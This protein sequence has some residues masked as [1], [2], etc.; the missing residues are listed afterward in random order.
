MWD[1]KIAKITI[2]TPFPVGDV[3]AYVVKG[4]VLT[5]IDGGPKTEEAKMAIETGLKEL[6]LQLNDIEQVIITHHHPDHIGGVD[7]FSLDLPFLGH[8]NNQRFLELS[9]DFI[10]FNHEFFSGFLNELGVPHEIRSRV[11]NIGRLMKYGCERTLTGF[12]QD[13]DE[14]PGL[15]GW[16][17][18][19]TL[20]HAQSHLAFYRE[21]DG[22]LIGG[23]ILL[24]KISPNPLVEPPLARGEERPKSQLQLNDSLKKLQNL[25][26]TA[27]YPGHGNI[28]ENVDELISY[29]LQ[30]Q[31]E[32][33]LKVKAILAQRPSTAFELCQTL[34][35]KIYKKQLGLTLSETIGQIDYLESLGEIKGE[36]T[37]RGM[38]YKG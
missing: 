13:G 33:A 37:E 16:K 12:I 21:S 7:F 5:L 32:R 4:D 22:A 27:V 20:G 9:P 38:V 28:I 30:V 17:A 23:D 29:R 14:L 18:V 19:E 1:N 34:F 31:H 8:V 15:P 6:G 36:K 10:A 11:G 3:Y 35:P 2:P 24:D 25:R 26:I